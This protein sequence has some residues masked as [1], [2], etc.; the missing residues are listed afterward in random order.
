M[1]PTPLV[2]E[3]VLGPE[4]DV[5]KDPVL[6]ALRQEVRDLLDAP[7]STKSL[8]T[9]GA[10]LEHA[11]QILTL[12]KGGPRRRSNLHNS[13]TVPGGFVGG[14]DDIAPNY[15]T[16]SNVMAGAPVPETMAT[17]TMREFVGL[18]TKAVEAYTAHVDAASSAQAPL[19]RLDGIAAE[20]LV[21]ALQQAIDL[22]PE[23]GA[24][25]VEQLK[26][27][28]TDVLAAPE[29]PLLEARRSEPFE[30]GPRI[31]ATTADASAES[32]VA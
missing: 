11:R 2:P 14:D 28:L 9:A 5:S 4:H 25:I 12:R 19:A 32:R 10:L 18:A 27:R 13:F 23:V 22:P 20:S 3:S 17:H 6:E 15:V 7:F 16:G 29:P 30:G 8:S 26:A 21:R 24:P 1:Q 31:V